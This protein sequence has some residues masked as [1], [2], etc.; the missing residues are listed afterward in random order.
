MTG[1]LSIPHTRQNELR[2]PSSGF[3]FTRT[4]TFGPILSA[5]PAEWF[6]GAGWNDVRGG[7]YGIFFFACEET[8]LGLWFIR[9]LS[10]QGDRR[11]INTG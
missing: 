5:L 10:A 7:T 2:A 3:P 9:I 4:K 11:K 6:R 1:A 8:V